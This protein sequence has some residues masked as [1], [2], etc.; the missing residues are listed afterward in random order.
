MIDLT[1]KAFSLGYGQ[2]TLGTKKPIIRAFLALPRET[3]V[4]ATERCSPSGGL[5]CIK[6]Q[7]LPQGFYQ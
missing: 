6:K 4:G 1:P 2:N 3:L 5:C 7:L